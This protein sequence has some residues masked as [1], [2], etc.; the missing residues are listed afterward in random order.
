MKLAKRTLLLLSWLG[1]WAFLSEARIPLIGASDFPL[2]YRLEIFF[3]GLFVCGIS[4]RL[5]LFALN[6]SR[7]PWVQFARRSSELCILLT[8]L[9]IAGAYMASKIDLFQ[10]KEFCEALLNR[11][12][13]EQPEQGSALRSAYPF[14]PSANWGTQDHEEKACSYNKLDGGTF[15]VYVARRAPFVQLVEGEPDELWTFRGDFRKWNCCVARM[16]L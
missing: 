16:N 7:A 4:V 13:A 10:K 11:L 14:L 15:I 12:I 1:A 6:R 3:L 8:G 2:Y 9:A 5:C